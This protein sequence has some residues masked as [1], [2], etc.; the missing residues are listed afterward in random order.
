MFM[1]KIWTISDHVNTD[2]SSE[3]SDMSANFSII[4][5]KTTG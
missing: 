4:L 1:Q 2:N 3:L 5:M